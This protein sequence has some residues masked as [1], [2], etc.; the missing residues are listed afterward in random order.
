VR[1]NGCVAADLDRD[2]NTDLF[3]T[4]DTNAALLWNEGDG[5]FTEGAADA[6]VDA[7][8]WTSGAAVGDVDGDR[9]P[10]LFVAGYVDRNAE[11]PGSTQG[12][13]GTNLG[14]RDLLYVNDGVERGGR[15]R[16]REV[17]TTAGLEVVAF[18]YGL[19]ARFTDYD[20]DGDLD[21]YVANDTRPNRL[22]AN[23]AWPG[24][25]AADPAGLGFRFEE[26]AGRAGVADPN[27]G[28]GIA[29]GDLDGD[30]RPDLFVTNARGQVH[31]A[32]RSRVPD[33]PGPSFVDVRS[34]LG[35]DL[36]GSTG[37]G[38]TFADLDLD[39]DRDVV[40]VNGAIPVTDLTAD[41]EPVRVLLNAGDGSFEEVAVDDA[42]PL[43]AR[44][45]AVADY[46]NDGDLDV[47]VNVIGG[48]LVLLENQLGGGHW[49]VVDAGGI[50]GTVV[51]VN[52]DGGGQLTCETATG[53][54]YLSS[55]DPRC[56]FGLADA[57]VGSVVVR[58]PDGEETRL[59]DVLV[60]RLVEVARH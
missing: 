6:G 4:T 23:V 8:G 2:G 30:L 47:A 22:Y 53:S 11:I 25:A 5:T 49:L 9:W 59:T 1:G 10:D 16:F 45:S 12:F 60:D 15:A 52:L 54:S 26:L 27:A 35:P 19:G 7:P 44:G 46:D 50:P 38:V 13:P 43:V 29:A 14:A 17:G 20:V 36:D 48:P 55:E 40:F 31:A 32:Y 37:W 42:G 39:A 18:E 21:L 57:S 51:D 3:V 56:H 28:M 41:A 33:G 58:W 34:E 24:G